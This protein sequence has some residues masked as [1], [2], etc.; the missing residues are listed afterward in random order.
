MKRLYNWILSLLNRDSTDKSPEFEDVGTESNKTETSEELNEPSDDEED[1]PMNDLMKADQTSPSYTSPVL[2]EDNHLMDKV[3][4]ALS[5][6]NI[7]PINFDLYNF[8]TNEPHMSIHVKSKLEEPSERIV[9]LRIEIHSFTKWAAD[10]RLEDVEDGE[11]QDYLGMNG[12]Y[13]VDI[14]NELE[15]M[16]EDLDMINLQKDSYDPESDIAVFSDSLHFSAYDKT[17]LFKDDSREDSRE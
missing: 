14:G 17:A 16:I 2:F 9:A 12:P 8:G 13:Y 4:H 7:Q 5:S 1:T 11:I 10:S 15:E 3:R 6:A